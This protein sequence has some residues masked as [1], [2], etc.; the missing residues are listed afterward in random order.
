M[1]VIRGL[2]TQAPSKGRMGSN[3]ATG[4]KSHSVARL[5]TYIWA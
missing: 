4:T 3:L 5:G 1:T 2:E